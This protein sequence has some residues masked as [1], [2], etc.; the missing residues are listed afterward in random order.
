MTVAIA[1]FSSCSD[2]EILRKENL[3]INTITV[4][5]SLDFQLHYTKNNSRYFCNIWEK[6]RILLSGKYD[7]Y[8]SVLLHL[9]IQL[10]MKKK[11]SVKKENFLIFTC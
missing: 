10:G 4:L 8:R 7:L 9:H 5:L 1:C 3:V 6:N 2:I 11:E